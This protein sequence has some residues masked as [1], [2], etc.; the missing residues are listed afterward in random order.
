VLLIFN[1]IIIVHELGHFLAARWRGLFVEEFGVWFGKP[2]WRRKIRGVYYSL[3]TIPAG[4][5]VKLPQMAPMESIEG[6][7]EIPAD[8]LRPVRPLDK[9]IVAFAGPLFSFLLALA[10]AVIVWTIGKPV[11]DENETTVIGYVE[12]GGPADLAGLRVGDEILEINGQPVKRFGGTH[13]SVVWNIIRS[14]GEK[15]LFKVRRDG[16]VQEIW[17]GW[18]KEKTADWRRPALRKV[19]IG[20]RMA[21]W[22]HLVEPK[23]IAGRAGLRAGDLIEQI[24]GEPVADWREIETLLL[25][26]RGR[27]LALRVDRKGEKVDLT[28]PLPAVDPAKPDAEIDLGV[29][30]GKLTLVHPQPWEQVTESVE[31]IINMVGALAAKHSDVKTAHFSGPVGIMNLYYRIFQAPEGWRLAIAF[32]VFFNV[33][34]ALL[35]MLPLPV[36]DGGHITLAILEAIRRKP[37]NT[38]IVEI[39]NTA[40]ALLLFGFMLYVSFF[41]IGDLFGKDPADPK[42]PPPAAESATP[43]EP[44]K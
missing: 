8:Q 26:G 27:S 38:R 12:K 41:D 24:D 22:V 17:S 29:A 25:A 11:S 3:G 6:E 10:L 34:L 28:L 13:Q 20:P 15:I 31:Q 9:M 5:F 7:S 36:L 2:L 33:N 4:G 30:P 23:S 43:R 37:A 18:A 42:T 16:A 19:M 35:N 21:P 39:V 40:C 32:S 14:E 44:P 1:I